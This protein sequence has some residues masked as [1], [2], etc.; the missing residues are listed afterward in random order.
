M[1]K[2]KDHHLETSYEGEVEKEVSENLEDV[3]KIKFETPTFSDCNEINGQK[4]S[5]FGWI[6]SIPYME[7]H[8]PPPELSSIILR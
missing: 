6:I 1:V 4:D 5:R 3:V 2:L 7:I 8:S